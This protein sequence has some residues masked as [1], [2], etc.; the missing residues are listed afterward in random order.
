MCHPTRR[1][2]F[3]GMILLSITLLS[4]LCFRL[5][6]QKILQ[7]RTTQYDVVIVEEGCA[8]GVDRVWI[9]PRAKKLKLR[10]PIKR[11]LH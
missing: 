4:D 5:R 10:F 7:L 11:F 1:V 9:Y 8:V 3:I 6:V 2:L